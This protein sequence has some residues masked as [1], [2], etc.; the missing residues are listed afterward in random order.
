MNPFDL[1]DIGIELN[2]DL[3]DLRKKYIQLQQSSHVDHG[4]DC[5]PQSI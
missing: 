2:P 1:F 3:K 5:S 4:G